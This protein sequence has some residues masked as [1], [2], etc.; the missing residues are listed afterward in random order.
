MSPCENCCRVIEE[1]K[2]NCEFLKIGKCDL[3]R[4]YNQGIDDLAHKLFTS[5]NYI[6]IEPNE[7]LVFDEAN[8]IRVNFD[9]GCEYGRSND[10]KRS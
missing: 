6:N 5:P 2:K 1:N 3:I 8:E 9:W 4:W 10:I 7:Y